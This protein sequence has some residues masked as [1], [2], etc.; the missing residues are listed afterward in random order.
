MNLNKTIYM[1]RNLIIGL[2]LISVVACGSKPR[3]QL[4]EGGIKIKPTLQHE[5]IAKEV[6][7]ILENFSYKKVG[8]SDSLSNIVFNNL[9]KMIDQGKNYLLQSDIEDINKYKNTIS[10]DMKKGDLSAPF[11]IF[12]IYSQRYL[13]AM[14]Y[15]LTQVDVV[16]NFDKDE[17]YTNNREK[18]NWFK[19]DAELK[20]QWRKRVKLDLLNLKMT[21]A[22]GKNEDD[23][24]KETLR[25]RYNN[26]ISQ[27]KKTNANDAFQ[28]IM[29]SFT[30]A[31]D[32]H[33]TYYNPSF[34][35]AFNEGMSNT[36]E[37]IGARLQMENEMVTIKEIIAGG[38]AF[39][40]KTLKM[41]DRII[42]VA[43][44]N[45]GEFEDIVGWRLDAAVAKIKG[46]KGT[47][48]RLKIL[49]AGQDISAQP[50]IVKLTREKIVL[51]E[52]SAKKS[53]KTV[54]GD[55]GKDYRIGV[56]NLPKFYIDFEGY[57]KG[58]PNYKSTTRDV[59][60]ILDSLRK[61]N[62]DA[63]VLDL[64]NN[65]GGSL[66]EAIELTGLFIDKGPVVQVRSTNNRVEVEQDK[67]PGAIW[68]GPFG[69]I[70]NRFSASASEIFAGAIQDY[71]R[72]II[73]GSTSY[74]KGTVQS[75]VQ[76][77]RFISPTNKLLLKAAGADKDADTPTGAP[78]FGQI[79]V[80]IGKFYR[81]NGSSTQHKGVDADVTFPTQ[82]GAEKFGE[83]SEPAALPWDQIKGTTFN[84]LADLKGT[85][86]QLQDIHMKRMEKSPE[87]KFLLE[88]IEEFNKSDSIAQ[89][90]LNQEKLKKERDANKVKNRARINKL[91]EI[92]NMPLWKEG[93]PQPKVEFDFILDESMK[94]MKDYVQLVKK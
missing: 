86:K 66:Q 4:E 54:K 32:P 16:H 81:V 85:T 80:T 74:G 63:V 64:R 23:K 42:A 52:E 75:A 34:A 19:S 37:G 70:I 78:E 89:I 73:L 6:V 60:L 79:N 31:I 33:T 15:A 21:T 77:S 12:N 47:I 94:V 41:D 20:D 84:K 5:V 29:S 3:V 83:S 28:L 7:G 53:I 57:R 30:D 58:D 71:G 93:Q 59:R 49:P 90:S 17:N 38:P 18:L 92:H 72:G 68:T 50:T 10:Q 61:E 46:S 88:D 67:D 13:D 62:V 14:E 51:E 45:D 65:G 56:I 25:K 43:Q 22:D 8:A 9:I 40:E 82:Y 39:K 87:Y 27:A 11:Y 44:G 55:D 35:Q 26:L 2:A 48:V 36:L 91:L 24:H 76:M 69:V 1:F